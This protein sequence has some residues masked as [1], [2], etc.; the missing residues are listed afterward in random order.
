M[1]EAALLHSNWGSECMVSVKSLWFIY[2][3]ERER[4]PAKWN[5]NEKLD[6]ESDIKEDWERERGGVTLARGFASFTVI[7]QAD[8]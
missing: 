4:K 5:G 8:N 2:N 1:H 7:Q 3:R 6:G